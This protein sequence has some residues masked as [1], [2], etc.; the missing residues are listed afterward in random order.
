MALEKKQPG[1]LDRIGHFFTKTFYG[2]NMKKHQKTIDSLHSTE[3]KESWD[4]FA[5][6]TKDSSF[7][8][9]VKKDPRSGEK[10][11]MHVDRLNQMHSGKEVANISGSGGKSYTVSV[12]PTGDYG[13]S[14]NDWRYKGS[15]NPGYACKHIKEYKMRKKR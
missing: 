5:N 14:C 12:L 1:L 15:V 3:G 4:N 7:V 11:K 8:E 6:K 10:L 9:A 13:C 2:K